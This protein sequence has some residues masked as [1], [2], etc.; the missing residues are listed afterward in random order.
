M[1][2]PRTTSDEAILRATARAIDQHGPNA[3]TLALVAE[4]AGLSPATIVQRFGS[5]RGLLLAFAEHAVSGTRAT[6][7]RARQEH[8]SPLHALYAALDEQA[9]GVRTPQQMVNNLGLLQLDLTDPQL[10][11]LAADQARQA[12]DE[13]TALLTEA[14][15]NGELAADA[16]FARLARAVQ[17][18]YNGALILWALSGD[19]PLADALRGD[20][21]ET[22]RPYRISADPTTES[23]TT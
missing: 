5:R 6:F 2:R 14:A 10:R 16:P 8:G 17:V 3:L 19:G 20:L 12:H 4:E 21:D 18:T 22:L 9:S 11:G 1:V 23:E 13:I 7:Q 15:A